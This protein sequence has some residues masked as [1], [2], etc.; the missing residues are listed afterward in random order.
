MFTGTQQQTLVTITDPV[1]GEPVQQVMQPVI[2]PKTG[3]TKQVVMIGGQACHVVTSPDPVTGLPV[4]NV[5]QTDPVTGKTTSIPVSDT[6][7]VISN[8]IPGSSIP[9][10]NTSRAGTSMGTFPSQVTHHTMYIIL[11]C[12]QGYNNKQ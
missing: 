12:F 10:N 5:V 8:S 4:Q 3:E 7:T 9:F 6:S 1:T 11:M 2:D